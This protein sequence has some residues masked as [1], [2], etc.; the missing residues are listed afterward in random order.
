M[1]CFSFIVS[2]PG[3]PACPLKTLDQSEPLIKGL[4][5][6]SC[7]VAVKPGLVFSAVRASD[8]A[9]WDVLLE[10]GWGQT[11]NTVSV[12]CLRKRAPAAKRSVD[13]QTGPEPAAPVWDHVVPAG[14][15]LL[16]PPSLRL[17][18][19][20]SPTFI[21]ILLILICNQDT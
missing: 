19:P 14:S 7:R 10:P 12:V 11:S 18:A 17:A 5:R 16:I 13:Q 6:A 9:L 3:G 2:C 4:S 15:G 8:S 21:L 1:F 20:L